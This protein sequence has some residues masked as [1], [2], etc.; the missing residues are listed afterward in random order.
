M[1]ETPDARERFFGHEHETVLEPPGRWPRID[2][3]ELWAYRELL[4]TLVGRDLRVRYKQSVLGVGW[5]ILRPLLSTAI[6]TVV[7]GRLAKLPSEGAP[8]PLFAM[9]GTLPWLFFSS[10]LAGA[11][12]SLVGA[13]HLVTKVYFPRWIVPL[14]TI[15]TAL[16][17][18]LVGFGLM[19]GLSVVWGGRIGATL[20]WSPLLV[21][22]LVLSTLGVATLAAA[23]NVVYRDVRHVMPFA[24]QVWM[25]VT[26]VV[27]PAELVP[28]RLRRWIY[29][30]PA[31]GPIEAFRSVWTGRPA[32]LEGLA[33]SA[34]VSA[35]LLVVGIVVFAR[36]E[37]RLA[38]VI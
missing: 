30:N 29:L 3:A 38:D 8:Y 14:A 7:F 27:F 35:V 10:A 28:E 9:S 32:D 33:V 16:V 19:L 4:A 6:F 13:Q 20:L 31:A 26:P 12:E 17:D 18:F 1:S 23:A 21:L 24:L 2:F 15:G 34:T 11:A 22:Y 37:R 5:A 36:V 25:Y